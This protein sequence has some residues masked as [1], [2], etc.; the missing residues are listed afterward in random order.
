MHTRMVCISQSCA[1]AADE[2]MP[3]ILYIVNACNID[4][5][6]IDVAVKQ[7][8]KALVVR[9]CDDAGMR[10]SLSVNNY[11]TSICCLLTHR[12]SNE[13]PCVMVVARMC[14]KA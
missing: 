4:C 8:G 7:L 10:R 14:V 5:P 6:E 3:D 1:R 9:L 13:L 11:V 2:K 12:Y